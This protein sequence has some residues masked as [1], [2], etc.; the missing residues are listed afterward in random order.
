MAEPVMECRDVS[1][2]Y[3][4]TPVLEHVDLTIERGEL[5][6]ILGRSGS[7]KST[8]LRTMVGLLPP[9]SGE[10]R[11]LGHSLYELDDAT[12]RA[13]LRRVGVVFQQDALFGALPAPS[14]VALPLR[15]LT[16]LRE[17]V[18]AELTRLQLALVG[19]AGLEHRA[20]AELSGG[21][22]KR[23]AIAR[24]SI[25]SPELLCCDEPTAGLDPIAAA[26]IDELLIRYRTAL[27]M[28]IIVVSHELASI[29]ATATRAVML[30]DGGIRAIGTVDELA[31]SRDQQVFA[32]FHARPS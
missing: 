16:A 31:H 22:R 24:A 11:V 13:V 2:R 21:Q 30:D 28:T 10:V 9:V 26:G 6:A 23:V 25:L 1:C 5:V 32:F 15:E 29:R 19:L 17:P 27:G 18:I 8:L 12:R 14:N 4:D 3:D 20:P 7:G